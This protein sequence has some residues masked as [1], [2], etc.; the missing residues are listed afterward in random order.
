MKKATVHALPPDGAPQR[1][2]ISLDGLPIAYLTHRQIRALC[3]GL[4]TFLASLPHE[5]TEA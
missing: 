5:D 2:K 1:F 4:I 3:E